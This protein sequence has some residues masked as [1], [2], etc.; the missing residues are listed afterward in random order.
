MSLKKKPMKK[1]ALTLS[2]C[3]II[4]W[5]L[6]GTGTSLAWFTDTDEE[7]NNI[8]HFAEF[9][10]MVEYLDEDG[11]FKDLEGAT[12]VFDDKALYEPG[13]VQ[14]IYLRVTN[15]GE[16]PFKFKTAVSVMDYTDAFNVYG[17]KFHLQDYLRFGCVSA[18]SLDALKALVADREMAAAYA[19][20]QLNYYTP[21]YA[22]LDAQQAAYIA[23][24]VHMPWDVDNVAN[25]RDGDIP[26][27]DLG[28]IVSASQL[29]APDQ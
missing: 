1:I 26:R 22:Q 17:I 27:V 14:V 28:L 6:L 20:V 4:L 13:Y 2:L 9:D 29:N 12:R 16:V 18:N 23:V 11:N 25:Y 24:V 7:I 8:F 15:N 10:L 3:L 21:Q 19:D 5:G